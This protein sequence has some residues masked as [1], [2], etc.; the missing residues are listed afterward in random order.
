MIAEMIAHAYDELPNECCGVILGSEGTP[1]QLRKVRN[2]ALEVFKGGKLV[3]FL[4]S[5]YRFKFHSK[6]AF[7]LEKEMNSTGWEFVVIY[8]SHV[9]S[10]AYPS[11][12]DILTSQMETDPPTDLYPDAHY[13]LISLA[14]RTAPVVR[15]FKINNRRVRRSRITT[16]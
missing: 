15:A 4:P 11:P 5:P 12:T 2:A 14:K 7:E 8:H 10:P 1:L 13:V 9:A 3:D 6:D 16:T